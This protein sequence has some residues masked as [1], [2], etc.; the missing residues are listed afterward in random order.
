M[1]M[2]KM[3]KESLSVKVFLSFETLKRLRGPEVPGTRSLFKFFVGRKKEL[4][5][6]MM[7]DHPT[8]EQRHGEKS[9]SR[10]KLFHY[11]ITLTAMAK[12]EFDL[13]SRR[14]L[15]CK[16]HTKSFCSA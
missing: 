14:K 3:G 7:V 5:N 16:T 12:F 13:S 8:V 10:N 9:T 11:L 4:P 1:V 6:A 15:E 2:V